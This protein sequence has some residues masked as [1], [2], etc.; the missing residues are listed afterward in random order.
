[1]CRTPRLPWS[2][3]GSAPVDWNSRLRVGWVTDLRDPVTPIETELEGVQNG[4]PPGGVLERPKEDVAGSGIGGRDCELRPEQAGD[5]SEARAARN[6]A[7]SDD[8]VRERQASPDRAH[9]P[10][11]HGERDVDAAEEQHQEVGEVR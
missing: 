5:L 1:M 10:G 7:R 6:L 8:P 2:Q 4:A 9:P 3:P 11:E